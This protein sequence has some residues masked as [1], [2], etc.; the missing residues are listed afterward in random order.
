MTD[1]KPGDRVRVTFEGTVRFRESGYLDVHIDNSDRIVGLTESDVVTEK[2]TPDYK[3]QIE[4]LE[5]G[6]VFNTEIN[7]QLLGS[8]FRTTKGVTSS[9]GTNYSVSRYAEIVGPNAVVRILK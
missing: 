9:Y 1:Y 5:P 3:A 6:T 7:S 8:A 2:L 4:A